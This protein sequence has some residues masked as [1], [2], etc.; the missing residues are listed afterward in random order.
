MLIIEDKYQF[1]LPRL[2][3]PG[4]ETAG[5]VKSIGEGVTN[6]KVGDRV[7]GNGG[8]GGMAEELAIEASRLI[9]MPD[10]M[11]YDEASAFIMT[12]GTS[13]YALK[14]RGQLR[15]GESLLVLGAAGGI[16]VSGR[17]DPSRAMGARGDRGGLQPRRRSTLCHACTAPRAAWSIR[18]ARS[19]RMA[20]SSWPACSRRRSGPMGSDVDL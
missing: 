12:Y 15:A 4:G 17:R 18:S 9:A 7:L 5:I 2:F 13:Y 11:P 10:A 20:G 1:G 19:T 14:Q 8:S 16:G 3:S 6:V